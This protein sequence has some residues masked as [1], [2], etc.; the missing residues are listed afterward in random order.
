MKQKPKQLIMN[1]GRGSCSS[2]KSL[3]NHSANVHPKELDWELNQE[4]KEWLLD[5]LNTK[6]DNALKVILIN[7][8]ISKIIQDQIDKSYSKGYIDGVH[9]SKQEI[10]RHLSIQSKG[11]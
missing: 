3:G 7:G 8:L 5:V 6:S 9:W 10:E 11:K 2:A 1:K 4:Q